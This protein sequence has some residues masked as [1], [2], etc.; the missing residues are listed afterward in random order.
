M[1]F[2]RISEKKVF[3]GFDQGPPGGQD[4]KIFFSKLSILRY[5]QYSEFYADSEYVCL[6]SHFFGPKKSLTMTPPL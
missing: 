6:A 3:T 5:A 1:H 4:P 2:N